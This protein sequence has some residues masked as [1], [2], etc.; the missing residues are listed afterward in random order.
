MTPPAHERKRTHGGGGP[1][2]AT[3][4]RR[5]WIERLDDPDEPLYTIAVAAELLGIDTQALR[6]LSVAIDQGEA[7]PSG[8]QRRYSRNDLE[9]L[10]AASEL[11]ADG[12]RA[13]SIT[14]IL[15][16]SGRRRS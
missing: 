1:E 6:R 9:R 10:S 3:P 2:R 13:H 12:H 8:N 16:L 7:R 5:S 14:A 4:S 11:A 15:D